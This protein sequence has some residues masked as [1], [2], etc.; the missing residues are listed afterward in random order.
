MVFNKYNDPDI[1]DD[2]MNPSH[3]PLVQINSPAP[4][5]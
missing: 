5:A 4:Q 2:Q 3:G 1:D